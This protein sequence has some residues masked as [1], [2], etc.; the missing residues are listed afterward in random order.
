MRG[1]YERA[2]VQ[3]PQSDFMG[4]N[5]HF[6]PLFLLRMAE[7]LMSGEC[8]VPG[9]PG[10]QSRVKC[11]EE[12]CASWDLPAKYCNYWAQSGKGLLPFFITNNPGELRV[13][14]L[15]RVHPKCV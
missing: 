10:M 11:Y 3:V 7:G 2:F 12:L 1:E 13:S 14:L 6:S 4:V 8:M 9:T 5:S 15:G